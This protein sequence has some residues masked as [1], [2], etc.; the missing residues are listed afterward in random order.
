MV[1]GKVIISAALTGAATTKQQN[2]AVPYSPD[3]FADVVA[4]CR[5]EGAAIVHIHARRPDNGAPTPDLP[6][7]GGILKAIKAKTPDI[8]LNL[9]TAIGPGVPDK[10]RINPIINFKPPLASLNTN[11]MNFAIGDWNAG[12][13]MQEII[14]ENKF[15]AIS[16]FARKMKEAGTKPE[17]EVYDIGG[18]YN[19]LFLQKGG[20]IDEPLHF[21]F[22]FGVLGGVPF[23]PANLAH[24]LE[25]K[26]PSATWSVCG[27]AKNQF[28][29]ACAAVLMGGHIR[30]GLEDNTKMPN[31]ELA[32]GSDEQVGWARDLIKHCGLSVATPEEARGILH[33]KSQDQET[34]LDEALAA[35][36]AKAA[37]KAGGAPAPAVA[38]A[39]QPAKKATKK[40]AKK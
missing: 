2:P 4:K 16:N 10:D 37:E 33:L 25:L 20:L 39:P 17:I 9:S 11:S 38:P 27:V 8:V 22:V 3:E 15:G 31:G 29:A 6:T 7:I 19:V 24:M 21:Q 36:A 28:Q 40:A 23:S 13:V 12:R 5:K 34:N 30:V 14:F 32:K 1:E 18:L 26:P 35:I